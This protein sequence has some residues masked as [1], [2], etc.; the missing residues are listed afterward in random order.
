MYGKDIQI[1][2]LFN[3]TLKP[4]QQYDALVQIFGYPH[5]IIINV[6]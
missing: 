2:R 4:T 3:E 6:T 1:L 5:E